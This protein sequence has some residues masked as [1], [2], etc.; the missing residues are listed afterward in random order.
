MTEQL[1]F[2]TPCHIGV[3]TRE[4]DEAMAAVGRQ[5]DLAWESPRSIQLV[6]ATPSG[7]ES[8]AVR[9][10]HSAGGPIRI[11]LLEGSPGSVWE[12]S[13][14]ACLH[15]YAYWSDDLPADSLALQR[16]GWE[17]EVTLPDGGGRP[18][19]FAYLVRAES[20]RIELIAR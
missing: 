8:W 12:T 5:F 19:G 15:H 3:A 10:V 9:R 16:E 6:F 17:L 14:I 2:R 4:L 20:P 18:H 1:Q 11:E 7:R 13:R